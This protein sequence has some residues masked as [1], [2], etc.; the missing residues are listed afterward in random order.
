MQL[1]AQKR[2]FLPYLRGVPPEALRLGSLYMNPLEPSDGLA[3]KRF[4]FRRDIEDQDDYEKLVKKWTWKEER[5]CPFSIEFETSQGGSLGV[6]FSDFVRLHGERSR[7]VLVT[8]QGESGRR[9]KIRDP[10]AFLE[11][12]MRQEGIEKWIRKHASITHRSKFGRN[13]WRAPEIWMVTG[14]QHVTGGDIH[15]EGTSESHMSS[16]TNVDAG[17]AAGLPP[18][19]AKVGAGMSR[20]A[21]NGAKTDFAHSEERIW[22]AQFMQVT[23]EFGPQTDEE[24]SAGTDKPLPRTIRQFR[25]EDVPDLKARGIRA[26]Q[27]RGQSPPGPIPKLIGRVTVSQRQREGDDDPEATDPEGIVIDDAPYVASVQSTDWES[28]EDYKRYLSD[29]ERRR[30]ASQ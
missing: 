16:E 18:G 20:D 14:V 24:L 9:L 29:I 27:E 15:F 25:L 10:E 1:P 26:S 12:V 28:Y 5:D 30:E 11:E 8:I 4:E 22:A 7:S 2:T 21:T 23:I 3:S 17:A 6:S 19:M 13:R